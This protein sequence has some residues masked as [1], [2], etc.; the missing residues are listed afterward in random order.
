MLLKFLLKLLVLLLLFKLCLY[1]VSH[2]IWVTSVRSR[3][4][5]TEPVMKKLTKLTMPEEPKPQ[6]FPCQARAIFFA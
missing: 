1:G 2:V 5:R 4:N 3:V 6:A